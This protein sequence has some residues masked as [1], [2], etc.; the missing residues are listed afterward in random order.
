MRR[1]RL[2]TRGARR[3][4]STKSTFSGG[5]CK[6]LKRFQ[7]AY[8]PK[9]PTGRLFLCAPYTAAAVWP[10]AHPVARGRPS[11]PRASRLSLAP[12]LR[13]HPRRARVAFGGRSCRS[14]PQAGTAPHGGRR[15][16]CR[17]ANR[18]ADR[19]AAGVSARHLAAMEGGGSENGD[20][21]DVFENRQQVIDIKDLIYHL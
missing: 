19:R 12:S 4:A 21:G 5:T 11:P 2:A 1:W 3:R 9:P 6:P 14:Y 7:R 10:V 15:G 8:H 13:G 18:D 17:P 16:G 20:T